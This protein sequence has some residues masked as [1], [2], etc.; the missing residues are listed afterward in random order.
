MRKEDFDL[1]YREEKINHKWIRVLQ[2]C[3]HTKY[4]KMTESFVNQ[5][6]HSVHSVKMWLQFN[7]LDSLS[8]KFLDVL[9][10]EAN[11]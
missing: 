10:C 4:F 11:I 6:K 7:H 9:H 8:Y 2:S 3:N 1:T 5:E